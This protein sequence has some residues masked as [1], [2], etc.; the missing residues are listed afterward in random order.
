MAA[1]RFVHVVVLY[2]YAVVF[3]AYA[4]VL[5]AY[6]VK[7]KYFDKHCKGHAFVQ[8]TVIPRT[9]T[10]SYTNNHTSN[11]QLAQ[12]DTTTIQR[13]YNESTTSTR[14][15]SS[16]STIRTAFMDDEVWVLMLLAEYTT[17]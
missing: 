3:Y 5:Y 9:F 14:A 8:P 10:H 13:L 7:Y 12:H 6:A 2:A 11:T 15:S 17:T 1:L 4:V 16:C